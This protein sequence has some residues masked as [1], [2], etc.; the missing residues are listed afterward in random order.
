[1]MYGCADCVPAH[2]DELVYPDAGA[3]N[4]QGSNRHEPIAQELE[5]LGGLKGPEREIILV[6]SI[7]VGLWLTGSMLETTLNLPTTLLSSAVVAIGAVALLS[8]EEIVDWNDLRGV[9]W[10]VFFVIGAGLTLGDALAKTG[11]SEWFA[12][13]LAPTLGGLP[14]PAILGHPDADRLLANAV[15][16]QCDDWRDHGA[17]ADH[18]GGGDGHAACQSGD[19]DHY[20]GGAGVHAAQRIGTHDDGSG[21]GRRGPAHDDALRADRRYAGVV[22]FVRIL[23]CG[24]GVGAVLGRPELAVC[25]RTT[26]FGHV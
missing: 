9:N 18:A 4:R 16:E 15:D 5:R 13:Q 12:A 1:M 24:V 3:A 26:A 20:G 2:S 11:A 7:S 21:D 8:I 25:D 17:G 23:L 10:G 6:L 14:F 19:S 22:G